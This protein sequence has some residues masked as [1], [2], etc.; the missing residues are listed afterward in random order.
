MEFPW[1][2]S[3]RDLLAHY[4]VDPQRGLS[5]TDAAKHAQLYGKNGAERPLLVLCYYLLMVLCRTTGRA[6]NAPL[7][8]NFG[9]I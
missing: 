7:A 1:T 5:A 2:I 6:C 8:V 4:N 9:A 3:P